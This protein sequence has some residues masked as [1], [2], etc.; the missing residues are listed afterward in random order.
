MSGQETS[1]RDCRLVEVLA[2]MLCSALAWE[3]EHNCQYA[4][5]ERGPAQGSRGIHV[6][7]TDF[8]LTRRNG[9]DAILKCWSEWS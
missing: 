6:V 4:Q 1:V 8:H 3:N 5:P 7:Y 2:D 9:Q